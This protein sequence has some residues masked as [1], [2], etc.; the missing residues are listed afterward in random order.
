MKPNLLNH[1]VLGVFML[2]G[3]I[4][5]FRHLRIFNSEPDL[6]LVFLLLFVHYHDRTRSLIAA[7]VF[8]LAY[9]AFL[10]L[11]GLHMF[12]KVAMV[13]F[14]YNFMPR[15]EDSKPQ[16]LQIFITMVA[17]T[18]FHNAVLLGVSAFIQSLSTSSYFVE[19][20]L[21]NT[22]FTA[23]IGTFLYFF[24]TEQV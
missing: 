9:D 11:W 5:I 24:K 18:F 4:M 3:Q 21:G 15:P 6:I 10:D 19:I 13:M 23:I 7:A 14:C 22:I 8:G 2:V 1:I 16:L 12:A 20:L 17:I